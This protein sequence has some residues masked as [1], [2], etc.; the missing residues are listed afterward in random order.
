MVHF[1]VKSEQKRPNVRRY[2][3]SLTPCSSTRI[4][5]SSTH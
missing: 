3:T 4:C 5:L 2:L 1:E